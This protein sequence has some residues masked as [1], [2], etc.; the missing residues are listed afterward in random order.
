MSRTLDLKTP[1]RAHSSDN[2]SDARTHCTSNSEGFREAA[3][4]A[5]ST[6]HRL[7]FAEVRRGTSAIADFWNGQRSPANSAVPAG[8]SPDPKP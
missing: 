7:H 4:R 6:A 8:S 1:K 5:K 3:P 2:E